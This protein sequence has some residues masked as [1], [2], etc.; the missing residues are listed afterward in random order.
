MA[1]PPQVV[2]SLGPNA[3]VDGS[4]MNNRPSVMLLAVSLAYPKVVENCGG[5]PFD[6]SFEF[7][8]REEKYLGA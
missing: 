5:R 6:L 1:Y 3:S 4:E 8:E 2:T 7:K